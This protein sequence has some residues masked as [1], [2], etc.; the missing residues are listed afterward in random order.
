MTTFVAVKATI[1]YVPDEE[2]FDHGDSVVV[3]YK[4]LAPN[5]VVKEW[6][7]EELCMDTGD[8]VID[9]L[10]GQAKGRGVYTLI[11]IMGMWGTKDSI[12]GESLSHSIVDKLVS[13][14]RLEREHFNFKKHNI[15]EV[16]LDA[17]FTS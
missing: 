6:A 16:A 8:A 10:K 5:K 13:I 9:I 4:I 12:T 14:T 3:S 2:I 7:N 11:F 17:F 15:K 1:I